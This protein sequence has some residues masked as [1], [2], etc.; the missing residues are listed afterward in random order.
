MENILVTQRC[1]AKNHEQ[2]NAYVRDIKELRE[3]APGY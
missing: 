2:H 3:M 1:G